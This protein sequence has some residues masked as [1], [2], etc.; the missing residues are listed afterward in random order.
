MRKKSN[1]S[2]DMQ[3]PN[4]GTNGTN[5]QY[6]KNQGNRG[7]QLNP[8]QKSKNEKMKKIFALTFFVF[9]F[10]SLFAQSTKIDYSENLQKDIVQIIDNKYVINACWLLTSSNNDN[11]QVKFF[12]TAPVSVLSRDKFVLYSTSLFTTSV[13]FTVAAFLEELDF[14]D[15]DFNNVDDTKIIILD[16]PIGAVDLELSLIMTKNGLQMSFSSDG[17]KENITLTWDEF[18]EFIV[19][20]K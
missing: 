10:A 11:I 7:K 2:A 14:K 8:N 9:F 17:E 16:E 4:K 15:L 3:N 1:N 5:K 13:I 18:S 19:R 12:S 20:K 6:D